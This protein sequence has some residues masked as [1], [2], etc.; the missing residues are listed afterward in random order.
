VVSF[1]MMQ[2]LGVFAE[3]NTEEDQKRTAR[4]NAFLFYELGVFA[5]LVQL[6]SMEVEYVDLFIFSGLTVFS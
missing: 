6:L 1:G 3:C 2:L 5:T 4:Q